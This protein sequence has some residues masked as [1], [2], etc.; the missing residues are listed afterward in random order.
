MYMFP[1]SSTRRLSDL[2][3]M[4]SIL[5]CPL[6][7]FKRLLTHVKRESNYARVMLFNPTFNNISV[8]LWR[9]DLLVEE[10]AV[11]G[12]NYPPVAIQ[13]QSL[14]HNVVSSTPHLSGIRTHNEKY[15]IHKNNYNAMFLSAIHYIFKK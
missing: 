3:I 13:W 6:G 8:I 1:L 4:L 14:S 11:P 9:S 2:T 7:F 12:E 15:Q 10:T 5:H